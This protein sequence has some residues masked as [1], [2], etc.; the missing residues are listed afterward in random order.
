MSTTAEETPHVHPDSIAGAIY[1]IFPRIYGTGSNFIYIIWALGTVLLLYTFFY[2]EQQVVG[3]VVNAILIIWMLY[4]VT[5]IFY[6]LNEEQNKSFFKAFVDWSREYMNSNT[7]IFNLVAILLIM[8][9]LI[10]LL[11]VSMEPDQKPFMI[12]FLEGKLWVLIISF[13]IIFFFK[14]VLHVPIVDIVFDLFEHWMAEL[15]GGNEWRRDFRRS[16]ADTDKSKDDYDA[17]GNKKTDG[18]GNIITHTKSHTHKAGEK[19]EVFNIA[20]NI[21]TYEDAKDVCRIYGARLATY[22]DIENAYN[23][24]AE[25]CNYGWSEGQM[26]FFPTQKETWDK[27]QKTKHHKNKCGRPGVNGGFMGNKK[28]KFGVNCYGV[29]PTAKDEDVAFMQAQKIKDASTSS[30]DSSGNEWSAKM[31]FWKEHED[32]LLKLNSFNQNSWSLF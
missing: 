17:S 2:P 29:K 26:A 4:L 8:Y 9:L 25:W 22:D 12:S 3:R 30:T 27:L 28:L 14:F 19:E 32:K 18:S 20:N 11:G 15:F 13:L 23:D 7:E 16:S 31:K 21:Y 6:V 1:D 10:F 24:G 5:F